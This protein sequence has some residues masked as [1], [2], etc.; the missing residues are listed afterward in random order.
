MAG[1]QLPSLSESKSSG[2]MISS[3]GLYTVT[4]QQ[5]SRLNVLLR[6]VLSVSFITLCIGLFKYIGLLVS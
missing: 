1:D 3:C 6:T 4:Y 5:Q 2:L